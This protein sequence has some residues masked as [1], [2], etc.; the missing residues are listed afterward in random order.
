MHADMVAAQERHCHVS[1]EEAERCAPPF[2]CWL[3]TPLPQEFMMGNLR[4]VAETAMVAIAGAAAAASAADVATAAQ[5]LLL[6][7]LPLLLPLLLLLLLLL[8]R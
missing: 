8:S 6:L 4:H 7:L 5:R 3:M 2:M 1:T